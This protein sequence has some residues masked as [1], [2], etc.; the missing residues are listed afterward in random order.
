MNFKARLS[1]P[2]LSNSITLFSYGCKPATSRTK[3]LT[4]LACLF[5]YNSNSKITV[6]K[7]NLNFWCIID[8]KKYHIGLHG[9][10][11]GYTLFDFISIIK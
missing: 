2:I 1:L 11:S 7:D 6:E 5:C 10:E 3:S 9:F 8:G 4:N